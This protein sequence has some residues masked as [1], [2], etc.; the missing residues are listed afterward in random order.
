MT[1]RV[2]LVLLGTALP[3][4][5]IFQ[6]TSARR[7]T[8]RGAQTFNVTLRTS[9]HSRAVPES[10]GNG[11]ATARV[12]RRHRTP[13]TRRRVAHNLRRSRRHTARPECHGCLVRPFTDQL[14]KPGETLSSQ[15]Q[16]VASVIR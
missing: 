8:G 10:D 4:Y 14:S 11:P 5:G 7:H 3:N 6:L 15:D 2:V 9:T 1:K 13:G 12:R 16:V